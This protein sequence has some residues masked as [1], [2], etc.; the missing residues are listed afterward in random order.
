MNELLLRIQDLTVLY[1]SRRGYVN[2]IRNISL[3]IYENETLGLVGESGSGKTTLALS[4]IRQLPNNAKINSGN[5]IFN[6]NGD[7]VDLLKINYEDFRKRFLW[8]RIAYVPQGA[9]NSFNPIMKIKEHFI[10]TAKTRQ[11]DLSKDE[12]LKRASELLKI[13]LLEPDRVL[14]S[15]PHQLSGGMKQ[16]TLI[17]LAL[18]FNPKLVIMDE[19]TSALD[20]VS[21]KVILQDLKKVADEFNLTMVVITHDMGVVAEVS[22]RIGVMYAGGLVEIGG[23]EDIFYNPLHPYTQGLLNAV[24]RLHTETNVL[25]AIPGS[26]PDLI[27]PPPG[28]KFNPRCP[29]AMEVCKKTEPELV[30]VSSDRLVACFK[31]SSVGVK[32]V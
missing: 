9:M 26:P 7:Y 22:D 29:Y 11:K 13:M 24:P 12:I 30:K 8:S 2:A 21:Q 15:Y 10:E 6:E 19:P 4:I 3:D 28:C 18:F 27:N 17:A 1:S 32:N 20:V 14:N 31:Y 16:R 25:K 23:V 5:I